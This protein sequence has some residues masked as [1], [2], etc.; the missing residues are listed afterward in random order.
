MHSHTLTSN[1]NFQVF[2]DTILRH[3]AEDAVRMWW[4]LKTATCVRQASYSLA[5]KVLRLNHKPWADDKL[6]SMGHLRRQ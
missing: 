6:D 1:E 3:L 4:W 5:W 2:I